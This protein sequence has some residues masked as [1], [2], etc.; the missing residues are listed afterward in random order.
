MATRRQIARGNLEGK[1]GVAYVDIAH[2]DDWGIF[3]GKLCDCELWIVDRLTGE[4]LNRRY[5]QTHTN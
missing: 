2:D 5:D 3:N 4:I 1:T